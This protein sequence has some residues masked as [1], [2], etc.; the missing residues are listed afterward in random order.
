MFKT[1]NKTFLYFKK[2]SFNTLER[3][4]FLLHLEPPP[5]KVYRKLLSHIEEIFL[6]VILLIVFKVGEVCS[7]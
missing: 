1:L 4:S 6:L 3:F 5:Q 2:V 7:V